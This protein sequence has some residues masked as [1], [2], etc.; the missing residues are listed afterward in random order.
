MFGKLIINNYNGNI[1][2]KFK[3]DFITK[4][5]FIKMIDNAINKYF[6]VIKEYIL[7][8]YF[9]ISEKCR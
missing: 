1:N 9:T 4:K 2:M 7:K 5:I 3:K 6:K 8:N